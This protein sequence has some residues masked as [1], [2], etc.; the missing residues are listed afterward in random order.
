MSWRSFGSGVIL[1]VALANVAR[2]VQKTPSFGSKVELVQ[3]DVTVVDRDGLP[4]RGLSREDFRLLDEG[5]ERAIS[6]FQA[7]EVPAVLAETRPAVASRIS[8]SSDEPATRPVGCLVFVFDGY[9]LGNAA[10]VRGAR[11]LRRFVEA[12]PDLADDLIIATTQGTSMWSGHSRDLQSQAVFDRVFARVVEGRP[13]PEGTTPGGVLD[14]G[15][16]P[17]GALD[18]TGASG[19]TVTSEKTELLGAS[20]ARVVE[21]TTTAQLVTLI[22]RIAGGRQ[23]RT[24]F[25]VVS[26]ATGLSSFDRRTRD[27]TAAATRHRVT[28]Y[29]LDGRGLR[30]PGGVEAMERDN[31]LAVA[32]QD[33]LGEALRTPMGEQGE[34]WTSA[35]ALATGGRNFQETENLAGLLAGVVEASHSYYLLG[36]EPDASA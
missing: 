8:T 31:R 6:S 27:V 5:K 2:G 18:E 11:M 14:E 29:G 17:Q 35:L 34:S 26:G 25:F 33:R 20:L 3:V 22:D 23:G 4:V 24:L 36:F 15:A 9:R 30:A 16:R 13:G 28:I 32:Q 7:V 21:E 1:A 10:Q 12:S 19:E